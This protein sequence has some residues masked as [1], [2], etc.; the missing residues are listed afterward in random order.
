MATFSLLED[1]AG[2]PNC[3]DPSER[4]GVFDGEFGG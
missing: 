2:A 3:Y 4:G 1:E